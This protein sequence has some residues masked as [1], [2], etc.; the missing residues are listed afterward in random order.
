MPP[1]LSKTAWSGAAI[2]SARNEKAL[3]RLV[4]PEPL[5]PTKIVG[6]S[7]TMLSDGMLRNRFRVSRLMAGS[8]SS[9]RDSQKHRVDEALLL[10]P[11]RVESGEGVGETQEVGAALLL[12]LE[13]RARRIG[14]AASLEE[15]CRVNAVEG[16]RLA[17][18]GQA[19]VR[20]LGIGTPPAAPAAPADRGGSAGLQVG[21]QDA[22]ERVGH[23]CFLLEPRGDGRR[24][25]LTEELLCTFGDRQKAHGSF[26]RLD[27]P[28]LP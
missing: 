3:T 7:K 1:A 14:T 23:R 6:L 16:R 22:L 10:A 11:L 20:H 19:L 9:P 24:A 27:H 26:L 8:I 15:H 2:A 18:R 21:K 17:G 28:A 4:L 5:R 12:R 13:E 25:V